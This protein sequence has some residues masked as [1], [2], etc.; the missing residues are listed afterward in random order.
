M[1]PFLYVCMSV[2][3]E[4]MLS[5]TAAFGGEANKIQ[6]FLVSQMLSTICLARSKSLEP[7]DLPCKIK[8]MS[9]SSA[10]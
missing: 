1:I 6:S 3:S 5:T 8:L 2:I 4:P 9:I 10:D 7:K